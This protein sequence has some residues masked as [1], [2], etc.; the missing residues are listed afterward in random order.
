M[1]NIL[2]SEINLDVNYLEHHGVKGMKWG[3]R[4]DNRP[5]GSAR[6]AR[7]RQAT[8][9]RI[10]KSIDIKLH[11]KRNKPVKDIKVSKASSKSK[12]S[13]KQT[14][15]EA[16]MIK[17]KNLETARQRREAAAKVVNSG[18]AKEVLANKD[19][20]TTK[21]LS[22]AIQRINTETVLK[23]INAQQNPSTL[24][25]IGKVI[26]KD[27]INTAA[28]LIRSTSDAIKTVNSIKKDLAEKERKKM[29]A[30]ALKSGDARRILQVQALLTDDEVKN[31]ASRLKNLD[32]IKSRVENNTQSKPHND[33][34]SNT[35]N[36][37]AEKKV[38]DVMYDTEIPSVAS[39]SSND[40]KKRF[41]EYFE[42]EVRKEKAKKKKG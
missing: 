20:L 3:V 13:R 39:K 34:I 4:K 40:A 35:I 32:S 33:S 30:S 6:S 31:V 7:R 36:R 23:Q 16:R 29:V 25:K 5:S 18:S 38:G 21:Q 15:D 1:E 22:D 2:V 14:Q 11:P 42:E 12:K 28:N 17:I 41:D 8:I 19:Q 24:K 26:N 9:R 10:K 27:N 37:N